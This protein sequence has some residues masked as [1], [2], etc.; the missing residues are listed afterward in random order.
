MRKYQKN[1]TEKKGYDQARALWPMLILEKRSN[2]REGR[3]VVF[4]P[5]MSNEWRGVFGYI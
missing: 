2:A 4:A 3:S 5:Y 1:I